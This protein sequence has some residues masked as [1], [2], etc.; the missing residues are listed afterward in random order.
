MS[1][2]KETQIPTLKVSNLEKFTKCEMFRDFGFKVIF[3]K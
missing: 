2:I 3:G 1:Y